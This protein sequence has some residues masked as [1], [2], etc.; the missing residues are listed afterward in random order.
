M[1]PEE[2]KKCETSAEQGDIKAQ[3]KLVNYYSQVVSPHYDSSRSAFWQKKIDEL[4]RPAA[5]Y[6]L[7][8]RYERGDE[9]TPKDYAKAIYWYHKAAEQGNASAQYRL[10]LRYDLGPGVLRDK[11]KALLWAIKA[12]EQGVEKAQSLLGLLYSDGDG[13]PKDEIKAYTYWNLA[14][15][16]MSVAGEHR[17]RLEI[18]M[19][20]EAISLGQQRTNKLRKEIEE[21]QKAFSVKLSNLFKSPEEKDFEIYKSQAEKGNDYAQCNLGLSY[22]VG[23]GVPKDYVQAVFWYRKAAEQGL[24][25]AQYNLGRSYDVGRG[26]PRDPVQALSWYSKAAKLEYIDAQINLG[27]KFYTGIGTA[28]DYVQA[29]FWWYKAAERGDALAQ[30]NLGVC[31]DEGKGV[32]KDE[33]E[34]YALWNLAGITEENARQ[35]RDELEKKMSPEAR[36]RG[37]QRTKKWQKLIEERNKAKTAGK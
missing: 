24:A 19:T 23:R 31:Y 26:V 12:A 3:S 20:P 30:T 18:N 27:F 25:K 5:Q 22:D 36:L 2:L 11:A 15:V 21:R 33:V 28:K 32:P 34:A 4:N 10:A 8:L 1:T 35:Y 16:S 14:S 17:D 37:Q 7:G 13:V 9:G 6:E 29:V